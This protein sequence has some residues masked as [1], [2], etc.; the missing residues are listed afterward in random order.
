MQQVAGGVREQTAQC[1][2]T[3]K[4]ILASVG[5]SLD[6]LVKVN[7][8]L[9]DIADLDALDE[10]YAT[11]FPAGVPARRVIGVSALP[12]DALVQI[13]AVAGNAEGTPP[14]A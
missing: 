12:G 1:L 8:A 2:T 14:Q 9:N 11:F 6:D 3:I 7:I 10:V 13:D 5:H 4:A